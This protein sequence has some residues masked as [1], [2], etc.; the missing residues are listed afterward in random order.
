MSASPSAPVRASGSAR[1]TAGAPAR[2]SA[3]TP[4]A[5]GTEP[6]PTHRWNA[7]RS[8]LGSGGRKPPL[9]EIACDCATSGGPSKRAI[10]ASV[11]TATAASRRTCS[12]RRAG[13]RAA[14]HAAHASGASTNGAATMCIQTTNAEVA[15]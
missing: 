11:G 2:P 4:S 10:S 1:Q 7:P 15:A 9:P 8:A 3:N 14:S 13:S 6:V 12:P 5:T